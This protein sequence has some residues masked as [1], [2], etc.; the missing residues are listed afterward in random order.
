MTDKK[1]N[2]AAAAGKKDQA[3]QGQF[4]LQ[5]IYVKDLSFE[6]PDSP[7]TFRK[8]WKPDINLDLNSQNKK[9]QDNIYEVVLSV[10]VTAKVDDNVAFLV[11]VQQ[12]GLFQISG[13]AE[14]QLKQLL[15]A[16]CPN[17]LFPYARETVSDVITRGSFPQ[18][19]LA[20]V[21]F[22]AL[23]ADALKRQTEGGKEGSKH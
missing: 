10:T 2:D 5:R 15:G 1:V 12:A 22:D 17:I 6:S 18:L 3:N 7:D 16:F 8:E 20:P 23:Y 4:S 13:M 14:A 11:E 19:L 21:N 9:V